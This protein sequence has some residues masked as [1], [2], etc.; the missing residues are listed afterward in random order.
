[1]TLPRPQLKEG[2][3]GTHIDAPDFKRLLPMFQAILEAVKE[4]R[5]LVL[6]FDDANLRVVG[7]RMEEDSEDEFRYWQWTIHIEDLSK[8]L[9]TRKWA[10]INPLFKTAEGRAAI[11]TALSNGHMPGYPTSTKAICFQNGDTWCAFKPGTVNLDTK[12]C[13]S[14]CGEKI[15]VPNGT[16]KRCV[17]TCPK[18]IEARKC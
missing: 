13:E 17:P 14:W 10:C 7:F 18:C 12:T 16:E 1:M 11:A 5:L 4:T 8:D 15:A 2:W 3:D 6:A 9:K